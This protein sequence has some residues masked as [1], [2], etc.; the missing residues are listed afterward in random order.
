MGSE[1]LVTDLQPDVEI[2]ISS[3]GGDLHIEGSIEAGMKVRGDN[4][5][6]SVDVDGHRVTLSCTGDCRLKV[7]VGARLSIDTVGADAKIIGIDG[8]VKIGNVGGD[9]V[10]RDPRRGRRSGLERALPQGVQP[11]RP[12]HRGGRICGDVGDAYSVVL[13]SRR[14]P[15]EVRAKPHL[16]GPLG[17]ASA[18]KF[19]AYYGCR[20]SLPGF[21]RPFRNNSSLRHP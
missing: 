8:T 12:G 18:V 20:H 6:L 16:V 1:K 4:P 21:M 13:G 7:P 2:L 10:L 11:R 3:I 14:E 5:R 19:I 15:P 17:A 9:L